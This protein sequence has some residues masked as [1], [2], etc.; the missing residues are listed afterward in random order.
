MVN[1]M[2][3][4]K[5]VFF[6]FYSCLFIFLIIAKIV[7]PK[8]EKAY[9][10]TL[11]DIENKPFYY[12]YN[13][14]EINYVSL[15]NINPKTIDMLINTEDKGFFN[16]VGFDASRITKALWN[17]LTT[18]TTIGASTI[19]QQFARNLYLSNE[20]TFERKIKEFQFTL[21][22]EKIYSKEEILE[23]YFNTLYFGHSLYGI[24]D[25][26]SFFFKKHPSNLT[27]SESAILIGIINN[28][29][30]Y[31]PIINK[32]ESLEKRNI[33]LKSAFLNKI[34]NEEEYYS[35][36]QEN[37]IIFENRVQ[38]NGTTTQFYKDMVIDELK[39]LGYI[40]YPNLLLYTSYNSKLNNYV[41]GLKLKGEIAMVSIEK[42]GGVSLITG[43][44]SYEESSFNRATSNIPLG[45]TI[46]PFL[47]YEAL[48]CG[49]SPLFSLKSEPTSFDDYTPKN[50]NNIY[51]FADIN[52]IYALA[53][54]DNIYAVK[55]LQLLGLDNL[56]GLLKKVNLNYHNNLSLALGTNE[57]SLFNLVS[58]YS[59][60]SHEGYYQK[61]FFIYAI[62][63]NNENIFKRSLKKSALL[64]S[65]LCFV[66]NDM[67]RSIFDTN[68]SQKAKVTGSSISSLLTKTYAGKSGTS[69][70][71]YWM[72]GYNPQIT[73]GVW[74]KEEN[75]KY[76]WA[77][78]IEYYMQ[79]IKDIWY[80]KPD[81]VYFKNVYVNNTY[82]KWV[83]FKTLV[84]K[85]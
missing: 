6:A 14:K 56:K 16:H 10:I 24:Y 84:P 23:G 2:K 5:Y 43:N 53:T 68:L 1:N 11:L 64:D 75:P 38:K 29:L 80:E 33:I 8:I 36:L 9:S 25:A 81:N 7:T 28:P 4:L 52:M 37:P 40:N 17:N 48:S 27:I 66:L 82:K 85:K 13:N 71:N 34:I 73:L 19:S 44:S 76:I 54:S 35:S 77:K 69:S 78:T 55:M 63:S 26:S 60:F 18:K 31:S 3:L 62:D 39:N 67:M 83:A 46:K 74:C 72:I 30:N 22:I 51:E 79:D 59:I 32:K 20:K 65:S 50:N 21:N 45:S 70:D 57:D 42:D 49:L 12:L 61:P 47:Y 15:N 41:E 58:A